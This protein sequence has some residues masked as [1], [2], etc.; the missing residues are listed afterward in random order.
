[1]KPPPARPRKSAPDLYVTIRG[2]L[3]LLRGPEA[4]RATRVALG[5][6]AGT[7]SRSGR[8]WVIAAG[9]VPDVLAWAQ[10]SRLLAAVSQDRPGEAS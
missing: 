3:A 10:A 6:G 9:A 4:E 2:A 8:G 5:D 1:M 7:W